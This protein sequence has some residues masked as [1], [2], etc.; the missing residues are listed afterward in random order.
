M[1]DIE[2]RLSCC[3]CLT[4]PE[5]SIIEGSCCSLGNCECRCRHA[6]VYTPGMAAAEDYSDSLEGEHFDSL[7]FQ[8]T[9]ED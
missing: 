5:S 8:N 9:R 4:S 3:C 6:R 1:R 7:Y 2:V